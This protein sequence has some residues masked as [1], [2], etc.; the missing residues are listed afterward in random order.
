L[1]SIFHYTTELAGQIPDSASDTGICL[2]FSVEC[3]QTTTYPHFRIALPKNPE[4]I[5]CGRNTLPIAATVS[6]T[7]LDRTVAK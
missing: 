1:Q 6:E 7:L 3:R 5:S 4:G 2:G